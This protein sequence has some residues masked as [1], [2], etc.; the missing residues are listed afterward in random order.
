VEGVPANAI[1]AVNDAYS[2]ARRSVDGTPL[3]VGMLI[4]AEPCSNGSCA[5]PSG[6]NESRKHILHASLRQTK[7]W[8]LQIVDERKMSTNSARTST[9]TG[10]FFHNTQSGKSVGKRKHLIHT[11]VRQKRARL[12]RYRSRN[13]LARN[14]TAFF[15]ARI[16][17][18]TRFTYTIFLLV[19]RPLETNAAVSTDRNL[20]CLI[21]LD[22]LRTLWTAFRY[23]I[24]HIQRRRQDNGVKASA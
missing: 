5:P 7:V 21:I 9:A 3:S 22:K 20:R 12:D 16:K 17:R 24:I 4:T 11:A 19:D 10:F 1:I 15:L 8:Q 14:A 6:P 2:A 13:R 18:G 23:A